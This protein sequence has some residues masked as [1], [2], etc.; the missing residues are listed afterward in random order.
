M[1]IQRA[2]FNF[3]KHY[4]ANRSITRDFT[5]DDAV[6]SDFE[7]FPQERRRS[8]CPNADLAANLDWVKASIKESLFTSQFG[9]LEGAK[10]HTQWDPQVEKAL[11]YLP[12][13]QALEEHTS[14][15]KLHGHCQPV[16]CSHAMRAFVRGLPQQFGHGLQQLC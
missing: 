2:F 10:V 14:R 3:T 7:V 5:V 6:M 8:T 1:L 4:L 12:Q 16:S 13:A 11:S 9:Q 15:R